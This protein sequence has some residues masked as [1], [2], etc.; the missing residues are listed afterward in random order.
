MSESDPHMRGSTTPLIATDSGIPA[1]T[2]P[3]QT[4][5]TWR[6]RTTSARSASDIV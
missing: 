4:T 6:M 2:G 5:D 3:E 1:T